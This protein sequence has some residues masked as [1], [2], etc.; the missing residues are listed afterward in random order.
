MHFLRA[1]PLMAA[2]ETEHNE[3]H[4]FRREG[5]VVGRNRWRFRMTWGAFQGLGA[6]L[7]RAS[8]ERVSDTDLDL[9]DQHL[10]FKRADPF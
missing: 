9:L 10:S 4:A 2:L 1:L 7:Q 6:E 3:T 5:F 8:Q